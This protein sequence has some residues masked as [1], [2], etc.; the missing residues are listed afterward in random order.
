MKKLMIT[1]ALILSAIA[2][3]GCDIGVLS[4]DIGAGFEPGAFVVSE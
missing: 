1:T 2:L 3:T 4:L